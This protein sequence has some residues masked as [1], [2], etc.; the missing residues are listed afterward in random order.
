MLASTAEGLTLDEMAERLGV[1]RRTAERLRDAAGEMF[2]LDVVEDPPT[3]RFRIRAGMGAVFQTPTVTELVALQRA[4]A[5]FRASGATG[6]AETLESL[7]RK[8]LSALRANVRDRLAPDVDDLVQAEAVAVTP[9][10]KP[11]EDEQVLSVIREAV[12]RGRGLRFAYRGGSTPGRVRELTPYG[13]LFGRANYLLAAEPGAERPRTFRLD[14]LDDVEVGET[15]AMRPADFSLQ[16]YADESVGIYQEPPEEVVLRFRGP[17]AGNAA[18]WRFHPRQVVERPSS[19]LT[20]V[21]FRASGMRELAQH[22]F[23]WGAGV[24]IVAPDRLR[25]ILVEQAREALAAHDAARP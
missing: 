5:S 14:L 18:R 21:R 22:L 24:E 19:E 11:V 6:W 15:R 4:T 7:G 23:T 13:V 10:P 17:A 8:V 20:E 9:G 3:R 1:G 16:A 25:Q 2:P 12:Q